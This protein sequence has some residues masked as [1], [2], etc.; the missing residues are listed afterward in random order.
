MKQAIYVLALFLLVNGVMATSGAIWTTDKDCETQ[1]VNHYDTGDEV[2]IA[3]ENFQPGKYDW[4]ITGQPGHASCTPKVVVESGE[5]I[6]DESGSFCFPAHTIKVEE[7]GEYTVDVDG[8]NDNY[9]VDKKQSD[10]PEFNIFGTGA[11]LMGVA[12]MLF[13]MRR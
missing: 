10:V 4:T 3:G 8:K 7:C 13:V 11:V 6:V 1:N 9:R 12:G 2:W 5:Q